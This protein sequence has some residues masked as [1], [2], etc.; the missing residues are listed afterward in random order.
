MSENPIFVLGCDL[1]IPQFEFPISTS[2]IPVIVCIPFIIV[3]PMHCPVPLPL[4][5][6][7]LICPDLHGTFYNWDTYL[8]VLF[9]QEELKQTKRGLKMRRSVN[10]VNSTLIPSYLYTKNATWGT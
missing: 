8:A 1:T 4:S 3:S 7:S 10:K 5:Y 9:D 6:S 2:V